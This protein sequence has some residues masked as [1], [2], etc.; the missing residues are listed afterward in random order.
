MVKQTGLA[1]RVA[2]ALL[3]IGGCGKKSA[4]LPL[5]TAECKQMKDKQL[6]M[7]VSELPKEYQDNFKSGSFKPEL[8]CA[9]LK[10]QGRVQYQCTMSASTMKDVEQCLA[11][12]SR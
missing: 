4:P 7:M 9:A 1:I 2:L 12:Q 11:G 3:C 6:A 8:D 5:S 10:E